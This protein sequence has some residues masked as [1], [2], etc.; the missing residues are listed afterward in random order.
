[1]LVYLKKQAQNY[2]VNKRTASWQVHKNNW[3][4]ESKWKFE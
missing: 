2:F 3:I 1:M 4:G